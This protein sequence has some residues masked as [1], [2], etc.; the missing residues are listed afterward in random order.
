MSSKN[1]RGKIKNILA[2][3]AIAASF[4]AKAG[5]ACALAAKIQMHAILPAILQTI[6]VQR[7]RVH[8]FWVPAGAP[9]R[10]KGSTIITLLFFELLSLAP[11]GFHFFYPHPNAPL[12][13]L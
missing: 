3:I 12:S 11:C 6:K 8:R 7:F 2:R 1:S 13:L 9:T 5:A 4:A 10:F